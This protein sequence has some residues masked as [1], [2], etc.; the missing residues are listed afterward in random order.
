MA[1]LSPFFMHFWFQQGIH[2]TSSHDDNL[3]T[4]R[5]TTLEL[6]MIELYKTIDSNDR[7]RKTFFVGSCTGQATARLQVLA[8]H[9]MG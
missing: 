2:K 3:L 4:S 9:E 8:V 6:V 5:S 7:V 1:F